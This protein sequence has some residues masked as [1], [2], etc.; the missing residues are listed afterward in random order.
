M[1]LTLYIA[2]RK[3]VWLATAR[4]NRRVWSLSNPTFLGQQCH[5]VV[6]DPRDRKTL[7]CASRQWHLGPTV[8]RSTDGG[9]TWKEAGRPPQFPKADP[10]ERAVDHVFWLTPGHASE[11]GVWYAGTSPK[12]LFRSED[13]GVTWDPISGF[14]DHPEQHKW[15]GSDKDQTP[16]G[17]KLHSILVD[18]RDPAHLY[19]AMSGGGIFESTDKG[20]SW[21]PFNRG[22]D[23]DFAPPKPDGGEYEYGH[24]P[25]CVVYNATNPDRLWQQNHCGIYRADRPGERWQRVGKNMPKDI[26]DIGFG[27]V[28][29]PRQPDTAWV[30]PMDGGGDWPRT[31]PGG[32]PAMY[33]TRDAG[34]SWQRQDRGLPTEQAWWTVKRQALANDAYDP[35][36][37]YLGTT[38]G[39]VWASDDEGASFRCLF[40]H[41]P[42]IFAITVGEP[43]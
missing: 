24:D 14:N 18:P 12:G 40:R 15:V 9:E 22:V 8:F 29:H 33:M 32:K 6:L 38:S 17:G 23:M 21:R 42:H 37:L 11:P 5:H 7:L 43:A 20:A 41:L 39:E 1:A 35:V 28:T 31:S 2:T 4:D 19:L 27:I 10:R 13:G 30:F 16:D 36:G 3:G 26:G 34:A 25:H